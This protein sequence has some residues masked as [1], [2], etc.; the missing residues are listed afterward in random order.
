MPIHPTKDTHRSGSRRSFLKGT[1]A[2]VVGG[3]FAANTE[4][5]RSAHPAGADTLRVGL[6]GCGG[7]GTGAA[8]NALGGDPNLTLTALADVFDGQI[9]RSLAALE[10]DPAIA[11]KVNVN[12]DQCF[13][14]LDAYHKLIDSGVDVVLLATPPGFRPQHLAAAVAAGKHIFCEKPMATDAPGVRSVLASAAKAKEKKLALVAGFCWRYDYGRREIYKQIHDRAIGDIRTIYATYYT[15]PVKPMQPPAAR[16]AT[17]TDLE[18]QLRN[19]YNFTWLSG[20]GLVEQAVHSIDKIAWTMKDVPPL[21]AVAVG[22]RQTPNHEGNIYDHIEVNY[23]FAGGIWAFMGQRQIVGCYNQ[24]ADYVIG[25]KGTASIGANRRQSVEITGEMNWRYEGPK[26][27]MYQTEH[28]EMYASIR[29]GSPI[30]DGTWMSTS[31]MMAIMGRMAAYTGQEVTWEQAINSR[32]K[33]VPDSLDW[34]MKLPIPLMAIP[35][36]SKL[37]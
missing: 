26:N 30:N 25:S 9:Q 31:T 10:K 21:K 33:L 3:A 4:I 7:R 24:N 14:G 18:W 22:G 1:G 6:I 27:N 16:S 13:V 32:E 34:N 2:A 23:E 35:G 11:A 15:G 19:W 20:D 28:D 5:A 12:P 36:Q 17:C 37:V 8:V 29:S